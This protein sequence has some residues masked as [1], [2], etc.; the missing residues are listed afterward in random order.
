MF[1]LCLASGSL[2][3]QLRRAH[4]TG[5]ALFGTLDQPRGLSVFNVVVVPVPSCE[6]CCCARFSATKRSSISC[7]LCSA[8]SSASRYCSVHVLSI[9]TSLSSQKQIGL[10]WLVPVLEDQ[11]RRNE[12]SQLTSSPMN[13][14]VAR[15]RTREADRKP[16]QKEEDRRED[17]RSFKKLED[18]E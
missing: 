11:I 4:G 1:R 6:A 17:R 3:T 18:I 13:L 14:L 16:P 12:S 7:N 10:C 9:R 15:T 5:C 2:R 8:R